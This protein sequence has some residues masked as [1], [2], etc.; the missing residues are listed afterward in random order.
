VLA[1]FAHQ[2]EIRWVTFSADGKTV[3]ANDY[4]RVRLWDIKTGQERAAPLPGY[5][6]ASSPDGKTLAVGG[7]EGTI[8]LWDIR[9]WEPIATLTGHP[10]T[11]E[12]RAAHTADAISGLAFSPDGQM[13]ASTGGDLKVRLWNVATGREVACLKGH[14]DSIWTVAFAPDGKTLATC[15]RDGTVKLWNLTVQAEAATLKGHQGQVVAVA[16]AP[17]GNLLATAGTDGKIRLWRASPFS[18]TDAPGQ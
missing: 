3:V 17:D 11:T 10:A 1:R 12:G 2:F 15:S 8:S 16:F 18:E 5:R 4:D 6:C 7:A 9:S 14:T 13:L